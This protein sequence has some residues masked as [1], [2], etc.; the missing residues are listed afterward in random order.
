MKLILLKLMLL[1][2]I[3]KTNLF[4]QNDQIQISKIFQGKLKLCY[5]GWDK[6]PKRENIFKINIIDTNTNFIFPQQIFIKNKNLI[7][8]K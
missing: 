4:C 8:N 1:F 6:T 5:K 7:I 2:F 3:I